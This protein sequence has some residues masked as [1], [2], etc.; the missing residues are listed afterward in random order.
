MSRVAL[1]F[2]Y[3]RTKALTEM[4]FPPLGVASLSSQLKI[5]GIKRGFS[6]VLSA[7]WN[8]WEVTLTPTNQISL[9]FILWLA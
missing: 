2:P 6:T 3:F 9:G 5:L 7:H 1:V 4:L 8:N